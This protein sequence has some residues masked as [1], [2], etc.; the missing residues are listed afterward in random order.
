MRSNPCRPFSILLLLILVLLVVTSACTDKPTAVPSPQSTITYQQ[1]PTP[2]PLSTLQ[3]TISNQQSTISPITPSP[4][5]APQSTIPSPT[6]QSTISNQQSTIPT[7]SNQQYFIS[8]Q[9]DF[10][11]HSLS[12][13]ETI[14]YTNNTS[15][16]LTDLLLVV[17]ANRWPGAFQLRE[18]R[19]AGGQ[20]TQDF[21]LHLH[22]LSLL[23]PQPLPP[24]GQVSLSL[25]Y[26]LALPPIPKPSD[27][28]PQP[29][30]YTQA[31]SNLVDWYAY[32]PPYL[33]GWLV[34]DP[35]YWGEY[36]V[37]AAG[38]FQVDLTLVNAPGGLVIAASAPPFDTTQ[39][40]G[41]T[42]R[43]QL[44]SARTFALSISPSYQ[45]FSQTVDLGSSSVVVYSYAYAYDVQAGQAVLEETARAVQL[46]S[47][48]FGPYPH[49]ALSVVEADFLDG[50]EY[51]GLYFLSKGFYNLYDGT[52]NGY[53]T[54][55]AV[56][57]TAHQWWY[58]L[59]SN[60]QT[61]EPWLDEALCAFTERVYYERFY[62]E[63]LARWWQPY[64]VDYYEPRGL[65]GGTIYDYASYRAYRDAV[66]LHGQE[67]LQAVR[68][69]IGDQV[70]ITFL[71]AYAAQYRGQIAT[72]QDFFATLASLSP[73]GIDD[74]VE[75]YFGK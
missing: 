28:A 40:D 64:R 75:E 16:P 49:P 15:Q 61:L 43:Y 37:F 45:V 53:L 41:T 70:F 66:Y 63:A 30:G 60:D 62:P 68:Q 23:L 50:M 17:P 35:G 73:V 20:L 34:H 69:R 3:S 47:E 6:L 48:L 57:E 25:A 4:L 29:F 27:A 54:A 12:V 13:A 39:G 59:V 67:F 10:Y 42:Y 19:W 31:Q 2:S 71:K 11:L 58:G 55:I 8:A 24:G 22:R 7:I 5:F 14:T 32:V 65:V 33:D 52:P 21:S 74:L 72:R 38:D 46:Y 1:S 18:I 9:L 36:Q 26:D 51:D 44:A 56:H